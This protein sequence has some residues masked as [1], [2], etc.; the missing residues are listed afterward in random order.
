MGEEIPPEPPELREERE[1]EKEMDRKA[2]ERLKNL[3]PSTIDTMSRVVKSRIKPMLNSV[4]E[5]EQTVNEAESRASQLES[6]IPYGGESP[7]G[8]LGTIAQYPE[9][10]KSLEKVMSDTDDPMKMLMAMSMMQ[11][12]NMQMMMNQMLQM[13][14]FDRMKE[15]FG[16]TKKASGELEERLKKLENLIEGKTQRDVLLEKIETLER[17]LRESKKEKGNGV[18]DK[19]ID[20]I[21]ELK[22]TLS[23]GSMKDTV[24][25]MKELL[26]FVKEISP[27]EKKSEF[28]EFFEKLEKYSKFLGLGRGNPSSTV[29][30]APLGYSGQAPW[31][32]HPDARNAVND[33]IESIGSQIKEIL[34]AWE[35]VKKGTPSG[36]V[37]AK[38]PSVEIPE[39]L[40]L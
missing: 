30:T 19:L 9:L 7:M 1:K 10:L 13:E 29:T 23:G 38:T 24:E 33:F 36:S 12:L 6:M 2:V 31:W 8:A 14:M 18:V 15:R 32:F 26:A 37:T 25:A 22:T 40:S 21:D 34:M 27:E 16:G 4:D 35:S 39:E 3:N 11:Q 5:M 20:K 28:E 17:E